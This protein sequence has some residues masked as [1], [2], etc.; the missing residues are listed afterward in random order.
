MHDTHQMYLFSLCFA[1][2]FLL[3]PIVRSYYSRCSLI[4]VL[5]KLLFLVIAMIYGYRHFGIEGVAIPYLGSVTGRLSM[6]LAISF[7]LKKLKKRTFVNKFIA[8]DFFPIGPDINKTIEKNLNVDGCCIGIKYPEKDINYENNFFYGNSEK[9]EQDLD[10]ESNILASHKKIFSYTW[11][12]VGTVNSGDRSGNN[13]E[14]ELE[15][16][17][18]DNKR[19][20][21]TSND[22]QILV[23][24][25]LFDKH[26]MSEVPD[27][28]EWGQDD[29]EEREDKNIQI[30]V[31]DKENDFI[32]LSIDANLFSTQYYLFSKIN[33]DCLL[34]LTLGFRAH[35]EMIE[36]THIDY[37]YEVLT[38]FS[39]NGKTLTSTDLK[40]TLLNKPN[41]NPIRQPFA[42]N[43]IYPKKYYL[44]DFYKQHA[45]DPLE[46]KVFENSPN[47]NG[48]LHSQYLQHRNI[49]IEKH[50]KYI[51]DNLNNFNAF[52]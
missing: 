22:I 28:D 29:F 46:W 34:L 48:W 12:Y 45:K 6:D 7:A 11:F 52:S 39:V 4:A 10:V 26:Y 14:C 36:K 21:N 40:N 51:Q 3:Q 16:I 30:L 47:F 1:I 44:S 8:S 17:K 2:S 43:E 42:F 35:M 15:L 25:Y 20:S 19:F 5:S 38:S 13:I 50:K 41:K 24:R 33:D 32:L 27:E 18:F 49:F 23:S 9:N 37:C 31:N